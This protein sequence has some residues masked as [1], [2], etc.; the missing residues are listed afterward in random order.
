MCGDE[1]T[2]SYVVGSGRE[3]VERGVFSKYKGVMVRVRGEQVNKMGEVG[4]N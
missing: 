3:N 2:T 1:D 4:D